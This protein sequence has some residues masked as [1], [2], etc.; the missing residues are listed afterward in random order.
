MKQ[1]LLLSFICFLF[2][3]FLACSD[4]PAPNQEIEQY[5]VEIGNQEYD[6]KEQM[7]Y[8]LLALQVYRLHVGSFPSEDDNLHALIAKPEI[9]ETTGEWDGPYIEDEKVLQDPWGQ[10][11]SYRLEDDGTVDL[12]SLGPDGVR[13]EDDLIAKDLFENIYKE[14]DKL[15]QFGPVPVPRDQ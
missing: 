10:D 3:I 7:L 13:S 14:L 11:F 5:R 15:D 6:Y 12:R 1:G 9:I 2:C 8:L 4:Q